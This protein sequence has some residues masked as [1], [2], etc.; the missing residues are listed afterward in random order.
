MS[1]KMTRDTM[2]DYV[3]Q[4]VGK[5]EWIEVTQ[6]MVN[7]FA[8]VTRDPQFIHIDEERAAQTMFGGTIAHGFLSLSMLSYFAMSGMGAQMEGMTMGINYGFDKLRFLAP[9]RVGKRIRGR[10]TL[11]S[12]EETDQNQFRFKSAVTVDIEG[13]DKPALVAEWLTMAIVGK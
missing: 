5:S 10:S 11:L 12:A 4:E 1:P 13:E 8:D 2:Q 7:Q 9:V 3:G 6:E